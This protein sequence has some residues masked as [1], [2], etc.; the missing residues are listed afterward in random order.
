MFAWIESEPGLGRIDACVA[1]AG[2][3]IAAPL[4]DGKYSDWSKVMN[5]NVLALNL[6]TQL[7]VKSMLKEKHSWKLTK[8][9]I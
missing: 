3:C 5:L 7:S 9:I 1:N 8:E 4:L 2:C 6:C